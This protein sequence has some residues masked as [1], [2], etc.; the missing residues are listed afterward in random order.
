MVI[1]PKLPPVVQKKEEKAAP[2]VAPVKK[3]DT[4]DAH[5]AKADSHSGK[6]HGKGAHKSKDGVNQ[7][8][9]ETAAGSPAKPGDD[10]KVTSSGEGA[11]KKKPAT[12]A[13]KP[14]AK[15]AATP[16]AKPTPTKTVPN[17]GLKSTPRQAPNDPN[18]PGA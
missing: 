3:T 15:P 17:P 10:S 1:N 8:A 14:A 2:I 11:A 16:T 4:K 6:T 18:K 9:K 7:K 13:A 12:P 5:N